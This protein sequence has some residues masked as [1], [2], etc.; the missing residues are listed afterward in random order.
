M[1]GSPGLEST[2]EE[3]EEKERKDHPQQSS[4]Q[5]SCTRKA[6][7][8]SSGL[9]SLEEGRDEK[10]RK[11]HP[12]QFSCHRPIS[13]LIL[14]CH[15]QRTAHWIAWVL[16]GVVG[17]M[18][19]L[20]PAYAQENSYRVIPPA[21]RNKGNVALRDATHTHDHNLILN[22]DTAITT[23][24]FL[25]P[26]T[27]LKA[28]LDRSTSQHHGTTDYF[29]DNNFGVHP[30]ETRDRGGTTSKKADITA[31]VAEPGSWKR[32]FAGKREQAL[33][34]KRRSDCS[35][36]SS[37]WVGNLGMDLRRNSCQ[38]RSGTQGKNRH[39]LRI[40]DGVN[41]VEKTE[42]DFTPKVRNSIEHQ[43]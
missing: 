26:R 33:R 27:T 35:R 9:E 23:T 41:A 1:P 43:E 10:K 24:S 15:S 31:S 7:P 3:R 28:V 14:P 18:L 30:W 13:P 34:R 8:G 17:C 32:R 37:Q 21:T 22:H 5:R 25:M 19:A 36:T 11:D 6:M 4:C 42:E 40:L 12:Q 29:S 39:G 2:E 38:Q 20:S 16:V